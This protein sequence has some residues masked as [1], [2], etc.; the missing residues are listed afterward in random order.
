MGPKR[1]TCNPPALVAT[2]PP[3]VAR[4]ARRQID[5]KVQP[6]SGCGRL[7]AGQADP[8]PGGHLGRHPVD[9]VQSG[10]PDRAEH[11]RR[12]TSTRR[13]GHPAPDQ[14]GVAALGHDA[15]A[16]SAQAFT[17]AATSA[18]DPG[19][20][21]SRDG[22]PKRRVQSCSKG[23]R[24]SG[25]DSTWAAPTMATSSASSCWFAGGR[26]G[27]GLCLPIPMTGRSHVRT[28]NASR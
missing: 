12:I 16:G 23:A 22:P 24:T 4:V 8:C 2:M 25:S 3:T 14:T 11:D 21:T 20:T 18:V 1:M 5:G 6:G 19:R 13:S 27:I 7:Q 9:R 17:T 10:Q 15:D 28:P 26:R